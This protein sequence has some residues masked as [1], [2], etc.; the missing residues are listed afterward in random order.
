MKVQLQGVVRPKA[1]LSGASQAVFEELFCGKYIS[2]DIGNSEFADV[3]LPIFFEDEPRQFF[4]GIQAK[5]KK[6]V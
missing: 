3:I 4:I 5:N 1:R 6:K 2:V